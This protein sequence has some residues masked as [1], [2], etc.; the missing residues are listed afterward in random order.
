MVSE[1]RIMDAVTLEKQPTPLKLDKWHVTI[2][3]P[4]VIHYCIGFEK[5]RDAE[6]FFSMIKYMNFGNESGKAVVCLVDNT[7]KPVQA[8]EFDYNLNKINNE[9]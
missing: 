9:Q 1:C 8:F 3:R 2:G 6:K 4:S 5:Q 7:G